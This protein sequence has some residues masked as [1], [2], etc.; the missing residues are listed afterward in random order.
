MNGH[1]D[2]IF[3]GKKLFQ[4]KLLVPDERGNQHEQKGKSDRN[5]IGLQVLL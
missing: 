2:G 1:V 5:W 4:P 3:L